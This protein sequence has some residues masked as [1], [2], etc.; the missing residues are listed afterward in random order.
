MIKDIYIIKNKINGLCYIGQSV[1]YLTRFRKHKEEAKRHNY[2]YK[3][4]LYDDMYKYGVDNFEISILES[5]TNIPDEREIYWINKLNTIYPNGYNLSTGGTRY[6]NLKGIYH[7]DAKI[8]SQEILDNIYYELHNT[9]YSLIDIGNRYGVSYDVIF[10]INRGNTYVR[11]NETYPIRE[12]TL[13]KKKLER[14]IFD[15]KY[16]N[17]TYKEIA[18]NYGISISQV[19]SINCGRS[20]YQSNL[21]YPLR[22]ENFSNRDNS[23]NMI[24][25]DLISTNISFEELATKYNCSFSTIRRINIG[26]SYH[27]NKYNY[28]LRRIKGNLYTNDIIKIRNLLLNS[29]LSINEISKMFNV[30]V[31]IIKQ[32]N[33][34]SA[35]KYRNDNYKYP[36][37]NL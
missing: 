33:S 7:H 25:N 11:E 26:E 4:P 15:L 20:Q 18:N 30:D 3:S 24:I 21:T 29:S 13:S 10:D 27:D 34:G 5:K 12:L 8:T 36:L 35:L 37:R 28:P 9:N 2:T 31:S 23:V 19:K 32:I 1:D 22:V 6:P 14:L 16:S 17:M